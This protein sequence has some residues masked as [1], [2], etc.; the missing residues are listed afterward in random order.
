MIKIEAVQHLK[1]TALSQQRGNRS[2]Y[3]ELTSPREKQL[4]EHIKGLV[5]Q[6]DH[7]CK[8]FKIDQV[9]PRYRHGV[10]QTRRIKKKGQWIVHLKNIHEALLDVTDKLQKFDN[11]ENITDV[12]KRTRTR[13]MWTEGE[14]EMLNS[15]TMTVVTT[16]E[17]AGLQDQAL[18][19]QKQNLIA[20][21]VFSNDTPKHTQRAP[22]R[23]NI[24][25]VP[26]C[27]YNDIDDPVNY[28]KLLKT[29]NQS[30]DLIHIY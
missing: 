15:V 29:I 18:D 23:I 19:F 13:V 17:K 28:K 25:G 4:T 24:P 12:N 2:I 20:V 9:Q 10:L 5:P 16:I 22:A 21:N 26:D 11:R 27:H 30:P 14:L 1:D 7:H 6:L 8:M 3:L